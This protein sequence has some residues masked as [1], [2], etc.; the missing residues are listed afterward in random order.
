MKKIIRLQ[1]D[2]AGQVLDIDYY[3]K[4]GIETL[5]FCISELYSKKGRKL[6]KPKPKADVVIMNN[7]KP[8]E[9]TRLVEF[10][11]SLPTPKPKARP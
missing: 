11:K 3:N 2:C 4:D 7:L 9:L 6:K 5:G 8:K 10:I 1:C